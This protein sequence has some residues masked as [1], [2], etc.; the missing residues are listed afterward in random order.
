M[1]TED[2][3]FVQVCNCPNTYCPLHGTPIPSTT[4]S[5]SS[6]EPE[7]ISIPE[8][9]KVG[10]PTKYDDTIIPRTIEYIDSCED[11]EY[12]WTKSESSGKVDSESW[13]HRIRVNLPTME[14]LALKLDVSRDTLYEWRDNYKEF[15]DTLRKLLHKQQQMLIAKGLS[16]DYNPTI[17]KLILS[18]NHGMK[19]K[20]EQD[21]TSGG[22][23]IAGF[24]FIRNDGDNNTDNKT[25]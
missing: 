20:T 7:I 1:N 13:E 15:S 19:E 22:K 4:V 10:R 3:N 17:A 14:G 16:G 18:A 11:E 21:I 9:P 12:D 5:A 8:T 6:I 25:D 2:Q 23:A 24:N